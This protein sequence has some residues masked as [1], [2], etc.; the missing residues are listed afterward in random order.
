MTVRVKAA[1]LVVT[2]FVMAFFALHIIS[3]AVLVPSYASLE[4]QLVHTGIAQAVHAMGVRLDT[5]DDITHGWA[6]WDNTYDYVLNRWTE[7]I[8]S[9][10]VDGTFTAIRVNVIVILDES[11]NPIFAKAF[12]FD[13]DESMEV[14]GDLMSHLTQDGYIA[15]R[16]ESDEA[17]SGILSLADGVMLMSARPILTSAGTGP[18]RGSMVMGTL[19]SERMVQNISDMTLLSVSS[20]SLGESTIG[21]TGTDLPPFTSTTDIE[22]T[23]LSSERIEGSTVIH[24]FYGQ[25]ALR[26]SITQDRDIYAEGQRTLTFLL[27]IIAVGGAALSL[28]FLIVLDRTIFSRLSRLAANVRAI[29]EQPDFSGQVEVS[30]RDDIAFLATSINETLAA[31]AHTHRR[32]ESSHSDLERANA[33]LKSAQLELSATANQLRRLTRHLQSMREDEQAFVAKE[34]RDEVGQGLT[35]VKMDLASLQ[36]ASARGDTPTPAFIERITEVVDSLLETVRRLATGL[37]PSALEDLGLADGFEWQLTEFGRERAI[38]TSLRTQG[39]ASGVE[40]S[41]ALTLFRILQEAL[42]ASA[43]D[44]A[45]TQVSVTLEIENAYVLLV[46]KD[47]GT[48]ILDGDASTRREIGLSLIRE[49]AEI[50]GGG[51]TIDSSP[52]SGTTIVVQLPL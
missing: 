51:V 36:R 18:P 39:R 44:P 27:T 28:L 3:H 47:N 34:I 19:V 37:R 48:T 12:D 16:L 22:V 8:D 41:R 15:A 10:L 40:P 7:Y 17:M 13:S 35:A 43:E 23:P 24:D 32:L 33:D 25:P 20:S 1:A 46:L 29:G 49:R 4:T 52:E 6:S 31:L 2:S 45:T 5:L 11:G 21:L 9:H 38:K 14:P 30:G 26:V 50:F 42:L